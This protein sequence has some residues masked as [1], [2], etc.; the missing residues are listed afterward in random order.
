MLRSK[1][2]ERRTEGI[3]TEEGGTEEEEE[4][5]E[6]RSVLQDEVDREEKSEECNMGAVESMDVVSIGDDAEAD[7]CDRC[8]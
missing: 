4:E 7:T 3:N 2:E 1:G 8:I 6:N 5:E